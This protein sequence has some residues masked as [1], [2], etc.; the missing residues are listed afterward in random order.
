MLSKFILIFLISFSV[1]SKNI[2]LIARAD[3]FQSYRLPMISYLSNATVNQNSI[4][5]VTFTFITIIDQEARLCIWHSPKNSNDGKIIHTA[6]AGNILSDPSI[7]DQGDIV[8]SEYNDTRLKAIYK[9]NTTSKELQEF[10]LP[11]KYISARDPKVNSFGDIIV[12]T[13]EY[14][15]NKKILLLRNGETK[16]LVSMADSIYSYIFTANF[17]GDNSII[18]KTRIGDQ[19]QYSESRPDQ[20]T[21]ID[22]FNELNVLVEDMDS[23]A[24]SPFKM[25]NN[26]I[27]SNSHSL[28]YA[29]IAKSID[30]K[31]SLYRSL[32]GN[33]EKV[34][35]EGDFNIK[36][37][38]YF[39]PSIN[40]SG[41]IAFRAISNDTKRSIFWTNG[42]EVKK[43]LSQGD[44]IDTDL[45]TGRIHAPKGPS[46]GGG[47][48]LNNLDEVVFLSKVYSKNLEKDLGSAVLKVSF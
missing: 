30:G 31:R 12:R 28:N 36:T 1:F 43:F 20:I 25:F 34:I 5:D 18:L 4:G 35:S 2:E 37:L 39:T 45:M 41:N 42:I 9:Y 29:F 47:L 3:S 15:S 40:Q 44:L 22:F 16:E 10:Y 19:G 48:T 13:S 32:N 17:N 14:S 24:N 21:R 7:N 26:T 8:F 23:N 11:K 38:E 33:V 46:F 27:G 6:S